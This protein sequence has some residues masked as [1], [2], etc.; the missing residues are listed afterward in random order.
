MPTPAGSSGCGCGCPIPRMTDPAAPDAPRQGLASRI[1]A[2]VGTTFLRRVMLLAA[3]FGAIAALAHAPF[4]LWPLGPLG[5]AGLF[6]LFRGARRIWP[7]FW[8]GWAGGAGYFAAALFWIVE[9]FLVDVARHGWMAPFALVFISGGL[10]LFWGGA[11]A[12]AFRLGRGPLAWIAA[13]TGAELMRSYVLTGFP[14]ALI[15]YVWSASPAVHWAAWIGPHGLS[16]LALAV[17][18]TLWRLA[19][20]GWRRA[21]PLALV[22]TGL[23]AAGVRIGQPVPPAPDAPVIRMVQPN[24]PQHQKWDPDHIFTF[25]DRQLDFT[26]RHVDGPAPD[27]IVWPETAIPWFLRD[28]QTPLAMVADAAAETPVV[29]GLR[30]L[31]GGRRLYNA[32]ILLDAEGQIAARY[33]K[34]HLVPFGEYI[35]FGDLAAKLGISGLAATEG[36]GYS[37]G[38]GAALVDL[39]GIGPALPLICYEA[40]FPQ[41]VA[42]APARP[43]LLLQ[44]TNDA[45]FGRFSGPYQHLQQ[46]RMRAIEQGL[47]MLRVANTG[48][49]AMIGPRGTILHRIPLGEAGFADVALPPALPPTPYARTGDWPAL[50]FV[51]AALAAAVAAGRRQAVSKQPG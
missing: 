15:G 14:W 46:A 4:N 43:R 28:A 10:A 7:A 5:L 30:Q 24:A 51:L 38:P 26:A 34:H 41:D 13:L 23:I 20:P 36:F 40:V 47:P 22:W 45:W 8:I 33:D 50:V 37:A 21:L 12:L 25:F 6:T 42:A 49:S 27:L 31:E 11:F 19:T 18:V 39:P 29:L 35:P 32:L 3:L 48:V 9:P 16:A 2:R 1:E 17:A 44:I